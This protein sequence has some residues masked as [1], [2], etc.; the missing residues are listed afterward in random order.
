MST[1]HLIGEVFNKALN[2]KIPV[3]LPT[4]WNDIKRLPEVVDPAVKAAAL[5][6]VKIPFENGKLFKLEDMQQ[7]D[8]L[9]I[10]SQTDPNNHCS[11]QGRTISGVSIKANHAQQDQ[12]KQQ[13]A[14]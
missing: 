14:N 5:T 13:L 7:I 3:Y 10:T 6:T 8:E 4:I 11:V 9:L 1:K 12:T 2:K